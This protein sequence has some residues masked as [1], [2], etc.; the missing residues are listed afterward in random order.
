MVGDTLHW[1][2]LVLLIINLVATVGLYRTWVR[3]G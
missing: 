2:V 3:R 1:I